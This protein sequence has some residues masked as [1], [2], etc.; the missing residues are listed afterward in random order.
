MVTTSTIT[1][2]RS[3]D[4]NYDKIPLVIASSSNFFIPK[5]HYTNKIKKNKLESEKYCLAKA[6]WFE[7]RG[8]P[9]DGQRAVASVIFNRMQDNRYPSAICGVIHDRCQ[10]SWNC[11]PELMYL[12]PDEVN[13]PHEKKAWHSIYILA[14]TMI[15]EY[16]SRPMID[17]TSGAEY[18]LNPDDI[19]STP[20]WVDSMIMTTQIGN[21]VFYKEVD[22][23]DENN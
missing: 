5:T 19:V 21:H 11:D 1:D 17:I 12:M 18:F 23:D 3:R 10:F 7:A 20:K 16:N 13:D 8:E 2:Y 9:L 14:S 4:A 22:S 15:K 6:V